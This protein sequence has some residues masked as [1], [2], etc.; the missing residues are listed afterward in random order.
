MVRTVVLAEKYSRGRCLRVARLLHGRQGL[1]MFRG[2]GFGVST[3]DY[4]G[5]SG[6]YCLAVHV[7]LEFRVHGFR[8]LGFIISRFGIPVSFVDCG[9]GSTRV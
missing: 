8:M 2:S 1:L 5:D 6:V 3:L 7:S 4:I 9:L